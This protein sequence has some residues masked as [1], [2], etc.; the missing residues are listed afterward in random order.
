MMPIGL[1]LAV[2]DQPTWFAIVRGQSGKTEG[3]SARNRRQRR[4]SNDLDETE[5]DLR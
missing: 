1:H 4:T 3:A 5:E 2:A